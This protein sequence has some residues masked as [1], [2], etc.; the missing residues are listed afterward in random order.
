MKTPE[1]LAKETLQKKLKFSPDTWTDC[2]T[3]FVYG[4]DAAQPEWII[5]K[6]RLPEGGDPEDYDYEISTYPYV[7]AYSPRDGVHVAFY[8][9]RRKLFKT[10][11]TESAYEEE[12]YQVSHWMPLAAL[13]E[14]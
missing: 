14:E 1:E 11:A 8:D 5:V 6:D 4:Y 2:H 10:S 12:L 7:L 9:T 13:P 3:C